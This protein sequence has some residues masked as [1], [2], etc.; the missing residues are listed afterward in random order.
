SDRHA[1]DRGDKP[2]A[3]LGGGLDPPDRTRVA[4]PGGSPVL[5]R[6]PLLSV[7][8]CGVPPDVADHLRAAIPVRGA[9][10][11]ADRRTAGRAV[12]TAVLAAMLLTASPPDCLTAQDSQFGI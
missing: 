1:E 3:A 12:V 7:R 10:T 11:P 4:P 9:M 2:A 5:G 6:D 8:R